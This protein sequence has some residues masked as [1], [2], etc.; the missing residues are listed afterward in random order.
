MAT[1]LWAVLLV[2]FGSILGSF[3]PIFLKKGSA[4]VHRDI[5][6][7]IF[8]KH[9]FIGL[10]FYA[11]GTIIFIPALKGGDLS[12]IYP[13]VSVA[14]IWVAIYSMWLLKEKMNKFKWIGIALII[15]GVS[16]IGLGS[17]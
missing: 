13:L 8:N 16:L 7:F 10:C 4:N 14:Y 11:F 3:G 2:I 15:L 1:Q 17:M 6:T 9:I 5:K 12:V